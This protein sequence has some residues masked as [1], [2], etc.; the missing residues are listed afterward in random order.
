MV[1]ELSPVL[2][3]NPFNLSVKMVLNGVNNKFNDLT[4]TVMLTKQVQQLLE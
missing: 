4:T 1:H 2:C 3:P